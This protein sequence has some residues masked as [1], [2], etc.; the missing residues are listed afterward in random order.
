MSRVYR[1]KFLKDKQ[2]VQRIEKNHSP[3]NNIDELKKLTP[4]QRSEKKYQKIMNLGSFLE[5]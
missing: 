3:Q 5:R 1:A 2:N 4:A